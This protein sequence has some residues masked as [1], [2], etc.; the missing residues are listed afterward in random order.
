MHNFSWKRPEV[1]K[2]NE[3]RSRIA[4]KIKSTEKELE[5]KK[6]EKQKHAGEIRK[7]QNDLEDISK[8][9]DELKQKS[10]D[11]GEKL[12]LVESQLDTYHQM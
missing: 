1:L 11:G 4:K 10:Q 9:L 2:L 12:Q 6:V 7:L 8:Q 3:E 5:K